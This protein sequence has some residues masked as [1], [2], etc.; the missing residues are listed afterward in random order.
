VDK[1]IVADG[2]GD[3]NGSA[4]E[5][6][7]KFIEE[8]FNSNPVAWCLGI[9]PSAYAGTIQIPAEIVLS[10]FMESALS[11]PYK[12]ETDLRKAY[13]G[14]NIKTLHV[15]VYVLISNEKCEIIQF[16]QAPGPRFSEREWVRMEIVSSE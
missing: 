16:W 5:D 11:G 12:S 1:E 6:E 14:I 4:S 7:L 9:F 2:V 13:E 10:A 8:Y 3:H 15:G